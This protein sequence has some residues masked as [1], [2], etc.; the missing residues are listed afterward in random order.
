MRL[1]KSESEEG[2]KGRTSL[3]LGAHWPMRVGM[4]ILNQPE[5]AQRAGDVVNPFEVACGQEPRPERVPGAE[6]E[7][8]NP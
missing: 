7:A 6:L 1:A 5:C 4:A 3:S 8:F 2:A